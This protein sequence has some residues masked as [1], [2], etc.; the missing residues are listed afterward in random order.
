[1]EQDDP[2]AAIAS[3]RT[4]WGDV[5]DLDGVEVGP[6]SS[7]E[8]ARGSATIEEVTPIDGGAQVRLAA[9]LEVDGQAKPAVAAQCL[10]RFYA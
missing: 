8:R 2:F 3:V 4:R 5:P 9:S 7:H 6:R 10:L 1:M